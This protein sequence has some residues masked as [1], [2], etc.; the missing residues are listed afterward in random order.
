MLFKLKNHVNYYKTCHIYLGNSFYPHISSDLNE[1][2]VCKKRL[3]SERISAWAVKTIVDSLSIPML[4]KTSPRV[5]DICI[6]EGS[7]TT[8]PMHGV[9]EM[10]AWRNMSK[11]QVE[12]GFSLFFTKIL[13]YP[14]YWMIFQDGGCRPAKVMWNFEKSSTTYLLCQNFWQKMKKSLVKLAF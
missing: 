14:M 6:S 2:G 11:R 8:Y 10:L 5:V 4:Q 12:H 13:A 9:W 3:W 1:H 7:G